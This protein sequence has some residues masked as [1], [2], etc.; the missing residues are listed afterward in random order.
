MTARID[1]VR[2][3]VAQRGLA[4]IVAMLI[5]ALAAAVAVSVATAQSQWLAQVEHRRDQVEAQSIALAGIA[6]ARAIVAADAPGIDYPGEPWALPLP[7]T[8]V[9]NGA[10]EGRIVDAQSMLNVNMLASL[11]HGTQEHLRFARLFAALGIPAATLASITDWVDADE[12]SQPNGAEDAW[13]AAEAA[14]SLA[15]NGPATRIEEVSTVRGMTLP[16]MTRIAPFVTAL[17]EDTPVNVNTAPPQVLA[18]LLDG[19]EPDALASLV[20]YRNAHPFASP[21]DF[22]GRLPASVAIIDPDLVAVNTRYFLVSVRARQGE[23]TAQARA[24]IR[25]DAGSSSVVWQTVE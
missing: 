14:P 6:G 9:E 17:P 20:A 1:F 13:Y 22:R 2:T 7:A 10:V 19:I 3:R 23:T 24:L 16:A 18:A 8:P 4:L 5:A 11:Q 21:E 25:R 12:V 15:A